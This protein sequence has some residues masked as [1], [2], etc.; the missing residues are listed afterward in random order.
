MSNVRVPRVVIK[1]APQDAGTAHR[2]AASTSA[3]LA[4][5]LSGAAFSERARGPIRLQVRPERSA[6]ATAAQLVRLILQKVR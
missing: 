2:I 1:A 3:L 5:Q 6:D 4:Q